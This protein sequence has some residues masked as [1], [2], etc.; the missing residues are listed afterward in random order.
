MVANNEECS[1]SDETTQH[2]SSVKE[3]VQ[4][5]FSFKFTT[6]SGKTHRIACPSDSYSSLLKCI[7]QKVAG[8]HLDYLGVTEDNEPVESWLSISYL[9]DEDDHVL[10]TSDADV[11]DAV[12]LARKMGQDRVKLFINDTAAP[13]VP[14]TPIPTENEPE[15]PQP[16][17]EAIEEPEQEVQEES[18]IES[19]KSK[20]RH[21]LKKKTET[22]SDDDDEPEAKTKDVLGI[23]QDLVLPAAIT[24]L[25]VVIAGVFV[26]SRIGGRK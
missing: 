11:Q 12:K 19:K 20:K 22:S 8:E 25:G 16:V 10:M 13:V 1:T 7:H 4:G 15:E 21:S 14:V 26:L 9:D 6:I 2:Q 5:T 18:V 24:F 23:P 17:M 3:N